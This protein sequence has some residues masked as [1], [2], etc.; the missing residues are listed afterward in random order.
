MVGVFL[1]KILGVIPS[2]IE[3]N[4]C[5]FKPLPHLPSPYEKVGG[6]FFFVQNI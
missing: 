4:N 2:L 6:E 5:G 1:V 3:P